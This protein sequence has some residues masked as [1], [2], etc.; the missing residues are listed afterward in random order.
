MVYGFK[1]S[2]WDVAHIIDIYLY[3]KIYKGP[4]SQLEGIVLLSPDPPLSSLISTLVAGVWPPRVAW[5]MLLSP[6]GSMQLTDWVFGLE[7][8]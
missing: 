8:F 2:Q 5:Y 4:L 7:G 6:L 3:T 1:K